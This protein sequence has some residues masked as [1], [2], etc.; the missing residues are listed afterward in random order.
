MDYFVG[1]MDPRYKDRVFYF[2]YL[3]LDVASVPLETTHTVKLMPTGGAPMFATVNK[4]NYPSPY[5]LDA[6]Q[7]TVSLKVMN[8]DP[9]D[10]EVQVD[11]LVMLPN[12]YKE[13]VILKSDVHNPC[14][15]GDSSTGLC[16]KYAYP[17]A[18]QPVAYQPQNPSSPYTWNDKP[19][20]LRELGSRQ[21]TTI[22]G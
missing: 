8:T 5:A 16:R 3:P 22:A 13:P 18:T 7:W 21:L 2:V 11:Y 12:D 19:D 4:N 15:A 10:E 1:S 6:A 20:I 9:L 17:E 14:M